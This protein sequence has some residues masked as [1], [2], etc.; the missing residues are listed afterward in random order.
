MTATTCPICS[1]P[2]KATSG[3]D[4]VTYAWHA[5]AHLHPDT[6]DALSGAA[7]LLA[8]HGHMGSANAV[9]A[10]REALRP[11]RHLHPHAPITDEQIAF[12]FA[13]ASFG[14]ADHRELLASSLL[15]A[16]AGCYCG[17]TITVIMKELGLTGKTGVTKLGRQYL[18]YA[19]S[20]V[21]ARGG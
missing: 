7:G 9:L 2:V 16:A 15:K 12:A 20:D 13:N 8:G 19:F 10:A 6:L 14:G 1:A 11:P 17:H 4:S 18:C 3:L 21:M 5:G